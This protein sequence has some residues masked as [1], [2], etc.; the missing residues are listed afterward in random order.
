MDYTGVD[1]ARPHHIDINTAN[2]GDAVKSSP[3]P[4]PSKSSLTSADQPSQS[5]TKGDGAIY[6]KAPSSPVKIH[7]PTGE[8][9]SASSGTIEYGNIKLRGTNP[10]DETTQEYA[11]GREQSPKP[12]PY[13]GTHVRNVSA[14]MIESSDPLDGFQFPFQNRR[15]G[16]PTIQVDDTNGEIPDPQTQ[17]LQYHHENVEAVRKK[18][19]MESKTSMGTI[20]TVHSSSSDGHTASSNGDASQSSPRATGATT[21]RSSHLA[22]P[23]SHMS[24]GSDLSIPSRSNSPNQIKRE[25]MRPTSVYGRGPPGSSSGRG[26]DAKHMSTMDLLNIPHSQQMAHQMLT[27]DKARSNGRVGQN[28]SLLDT[29]KTLDMYRANVKKT[30]D[31]SL[32]YEFALLLVNAVQEASNSKQINEGDGLANPVVR[33]ELIKEA[34][35]ILQRL[36]DKSYAY[37]QYYL[38]DGYASGF[39]NG[40]KPN[41]DKAFD[42]FIAAGK[43]GH[44]EASYRAALCYE[45][46]W[47]S[48]RD[49]AKAVQY[50]RSAA[51]KG[52]PGAAIRLGK[53]CLT[54]DMGLQGKYREGIKWLKRAAESADTQHNSGPYEL[55]LLHLEGYGADVFKDEAYAVQLLTQSAD[56]GHPDANFRMGRVYENGWLGCPKDPAL[57]IH[58]YNAAAQAGVPEGM[59]ALCAWYM[60]GAE[61]IMAKD[62]GEAYQWAKRAADQGFARAEYALG[63]FTEMGIGCRRDP[64]EANTWYMKAA[65]QGEDRAKHRLAI[66]RAAESGEG[67]VRNAKSEKKTIKKKKSTIGGEQKDDK[68]CV[69]M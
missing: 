1:S 55:G 39:F 6:Q 16:T 51:A 8:V 18:K 3:F 53:A 29:K 10:S 59:M 56:L 37:A 17:P 4:S 48:R 64:L 27:L 62:E 22:R 30:N 21:K 5:A 19:R 65:E 49:F 43:H 31:S 45:F 60:V 24:L 32:Q 26:A 20:G 40:G 25:S 54:G 9:P 42:L 7:T 13:K 2:R 69:V 50:Y 47:G 15:A 58:F 33:K 57:S 44:A 36:A 35:A 46:G 14:P 28:A 68:D 63:Y 34:R 11:P 66:I 52:H 67:E 61:P 12:Q 23:M 41:D 38:G